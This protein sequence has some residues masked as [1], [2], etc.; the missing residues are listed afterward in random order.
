MSVPLNQNDYE[1]FVKLAAAIM[2]AG[3]GKISIYTGSDT[4]DGTCYA[5]IEM[6]TS[7]LDPKALEEI[8]GCTPLPEA[9]PLIN[10]NRWGV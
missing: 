3:D 6:S 4:K 10:T 2:A 1:R 5:N 8:F 7:K 9:P